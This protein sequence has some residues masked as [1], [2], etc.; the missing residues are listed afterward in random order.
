MS[1]N[2][3]IFQ[4]ALAVF[5][6]FF[7]LLISSYD[8][9]HLY[10]STGYDFV[11]LDSYTRSMKIGEEFCLLAFTSTGKKPT[12]SSDNT[13]VAS[14]NTYGV[15]RA[16]KAG[17][18]VITAKIKN[19]EAGCKVRVERT[20]ISLSAT[21]ISLENGETARI[22]AT[23]S[24][25][26]P[27]TFRSAKSGIASVS[28]QGLVQAKKPGSTV[29]TVTADKTSV[30]CKVTVK[31]PVVRLNRTSV[32][33]Y[34]KGKTR[35]LVTSTSKSTPKWKSNKKSVATVE[36]DGTVTAVKHGTA[37][38]TVTVDGVSKSCEVT[39]KKPAIKFEQTQIELAAGQKYQAKA[40]VSSG[41]KPE[42]SS[43]NT[44]VASVDNNGRV[45]ARAKGKAY[46]YAKEDG[47]KERMTVIVKEE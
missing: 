46:I 20:T 41:N 23:T 38:V 2:K 40:A 39:V 4:T 16:K 14:V 21:S 27:V 7:I 18:A 44:N 33:L 1:R 42:Y 8:T 6:M 34:R 5:C 28:E 31:R 32:S 13:A 22:K 30:T 24:N 36:E 19:A 15:V 11:V 9:I 10:A 37:I 12:F 35:L 45:T 26:H 25:G 43:S 3:K 29:I 47:T 17:T